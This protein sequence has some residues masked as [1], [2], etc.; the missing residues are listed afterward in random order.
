MIEGLQDAIRTR[1]ESGEQLEAVYDD[2]VLARGELDGEQ[3]AALWLYTWHCS[4]RDG[5]AGPL[6]AREPSREF[7]LA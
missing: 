1:V 3:R 6:H 5:S 4:G 7:A 2:L